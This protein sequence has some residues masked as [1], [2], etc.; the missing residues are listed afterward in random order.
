MNYFFSACFILISKIIQL[1]ISLARILAY[2]FKRTCIIYGTHTFKTM[3]I[4]DL[5]DIRRH[6]TGIKHAYLNWI[7]ILNGKMHGE[8][9]TSIT[10]LFI[11]AVTVFY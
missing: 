5:I 8:V 1:A 11:M 6:Q 9:Y 3:F 7:F 10:V 2:F 4:V